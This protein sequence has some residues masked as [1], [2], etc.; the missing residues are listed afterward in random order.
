MPGRSAHDL[1]RAAVLGLD[2]LG[3][4]HELQEVIR[5]ELAHHTD[6][7][8][9]TSSPTVAALK[10]KRAKLLHHYYAEKISAD[11]F[12]DEEQRL[13]G[14]IYELETADTNRLHRAAQRSDLARRFDEVASLIRRCA[15]S[16]GLKSASCLPSLSATP[17]D[18]PP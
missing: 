7:T 6:L 2:L 11:A 17:S 13:T 18:S 4:D 9:T 14:R 3:Q 16:T 5:T 12:G 8:H 15:P 1:H 10:V